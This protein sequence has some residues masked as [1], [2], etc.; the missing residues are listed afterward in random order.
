[1]QKVNL[2][3]HGLILTCSAEFAFSQAEDDGLR[4]WAKQWLVDS[5]VERFVY[6]TSLKD[7]DYLAQAGQK[8]AAACIVWSS[9]PDTSF[10]GGVWGYDSIGNAVEA[11]FRQCEQAKETYGYSPDCEC[12]LL[13][14][15][16]AN[17]LEPPETSIDDAVRRLEGLRVP[18]MCPE[19]FRDDLR[20]VSTYA[21]TCPEYKRSDVTRSKFVINRVLPSALGADSP[22]IYPGGPIARRSEIEKLQ[23][24]DPVTGQSA[25]PHITFYPEVGDSHMDTWSTPLTPPSDWV[26]EFQLHRVPTEMEE[27]VRSQL[28]TLDRSKMY[29]RFGHSLKREIDLPFYNP[30]DVFCRYTRK[31][32]LT[33]E[34]TRQA[35]FS[36]DLIETTYHGQLHGEQSTAVWVESYI[37]VDDKWIPVRAPQRNVVPIALETDSALYL[38]SIEIVPQMGYGHDL[39]HFEGRIF[40]FSRCKELGE[41]VGDA[42]EALRVEL[43]T[44]FQAVP[45]SATAVRDHR[46]PNQIRFQRLFEESEVL[47]GLAG[48]YYELSTY[49]VTY[50]TGPAGSLF[51][52][53]GEG[54]FNRKSSGTQSVETPNQMFLHVDH[55]VQI[56]VGRKGSY[57]EPEVEQYARYSQTV[58]DAVQSAVEKAS[59]RIGANVGQDGVG[60]LVD[61]SVRPC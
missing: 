6:L 51:T 7:V 47:H 34:E 11:A 39:A 42:I 52:S 49:T 23:I 22:E 38:Y 61:R 50:W 37:H 33:D 55:A 45:L 24:K 9:D 8:A 26:Y 2:L 58:R 20:P 41:C 17:V 53:T 56:S 31:Y 32:D 54:Y 28:S 3:V 30:A 5:V 40:D 46:P 4:A 19:W 18:T 14:S 36:S 1:M 29:G 12:E 10:W 21:D 44:A 59:A 43:D 35:F 13:F 48:P 25:S 16:E 27:L 60:V 15:G 57:D